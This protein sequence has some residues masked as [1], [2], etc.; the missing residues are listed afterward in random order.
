MQREAR[1][2]PPSWSLTAGSLGVGATDVK[3]MKMPG[4][5]SQDCARC[6]VG[7]TQGA[8]RV[9]I[10]WGLLSLYRKGVDESDIL[11]EAMVQ[12]RPEGCMNSRTEGGMF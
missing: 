11:E 6:W 8:W 1:P 5:V 4:V 9:C 3:Q 10:Y 2:G 7:A 12:L